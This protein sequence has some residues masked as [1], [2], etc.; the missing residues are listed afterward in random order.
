[1]RV[2][3]ALINNSFSSRIWLDNEEEDEEEVLT[4]VF[5]DAAAAAAAA[6]SDL[7]ARERMFA[8]CS[9]KVRVRVEVASSFENKN[10]LVLVASEHVRRRCNGDLRDH[11][12]ISKD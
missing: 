6:I 2:K 4:E 1:M 12:N 11:L 3:S 7:V 10:V 9:V 8:C 5:A